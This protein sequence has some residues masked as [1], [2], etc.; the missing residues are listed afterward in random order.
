MRLSR[1]H[2]F[3]KYAL[4]PFRV[5]VM[6]GPLK[7]K[8]WIA[9]SGARFW[10]G[11]HKPEMTRILLDKIRAGSVY[12][13]V[14][15]HI[16]YYT[17]MASDMVGAQGRVISFEPRK[18]N[19]SYLRSHIRVNRCANV[20]VIPAAVGERPGECRFETRIGTGLGY[21]SETGN[22]SVDM[23]SLDD[24]VGSG[25][26]PPPDVI[27]VDVEGGEMGVLKGATELLR[28]HRPITVV[29]THG[30]AIR[31]ECVAFLEGE[32]FEVS[33]AGKWA[34]IVAEPRGG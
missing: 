25:R 5:R 6:A 13:D 33:W 11:I 22:R 1:L 24:L 16:G 9:S 31:E 20:E 19:L 18:L 2:D 26:L 30:D 21:V 7:G 3:V 10:R 17:V 32:E 12:F 15:A 29:S 28:Q 8:R 14:G 4:K 27:K 23:V 34:P